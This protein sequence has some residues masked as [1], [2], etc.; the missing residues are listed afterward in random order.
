MYNFMKL[1]SLNTWCGRAFEP[2][3]D[4]IEEQ[5][6]DTDIFCFQE[7]FDSPIALTTNTGIRTDL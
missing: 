2:L 3:L 6:T 1:V 4:F 5:S 7:M